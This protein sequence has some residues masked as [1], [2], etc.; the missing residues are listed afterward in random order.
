MQK[1]TKQEL[2]TINGGATYGSSSL[3]NA[4]ANLIEVLL[5]AGKILG[6]SLRRINS[7]KLC[8]LE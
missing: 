4:I 1:L 3:I 7:N 8:P 6:T 2:L 5:D